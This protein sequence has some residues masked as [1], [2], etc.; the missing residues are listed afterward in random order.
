M[1]R[2]RDVNLPPPTYYSYPIFD[3][4]GGTFQNEFYNVE[5]FSTWQ[6]SYSISCPYPPCIN[7]LNRP[8]PQLGA[9]DQFESAASSVYNGM[10]VSLRRRMSGGLIST[11]HIPGRTR[12]TVVRTRW[13]PGNR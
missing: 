11:W 8:I 12:S 5:S 2:A 3:P 7:T 10:T 4:T 1:I 13:W 9:I 6:T